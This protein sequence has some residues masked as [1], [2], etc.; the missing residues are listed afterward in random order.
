MNLKV[1]VRR[2]L[3]RFWQVLSTQLDIESSCCIMQLAL[4]TALFSL[5]SVLPRLSARRSFEWPAF[6]YVQQTTREKHIL[7]AI[8]DLA[9]DTNKY[10]ALS[11]KRQLITLV[12]SECLSM[13]QQ[14]GQITMTLGAR[15]PRSYHNTRFPGIPGLSGFPSQSHGPLK[16][17]KR[18]QVSDLI[19]MIW[20]CMAK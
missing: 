1:G 18:Y 11:W 14:R 5:E 13:N 10:D 8:N 12:V 9:E 4:P 6:V 16:I 2:H 19:L 3:V 15:G 20:E 7:E 17:Y